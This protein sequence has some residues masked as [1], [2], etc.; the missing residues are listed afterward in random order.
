MLV[1]AT[2]T[3]VMKPDDWTAIALELMY[4][5]PQLGECVASLDDRALERRRSH[6]LADPLELV[7]K[8]VAHRPVVVLGW[9]GE[10]D[11]Q[12]TS[13]SGIL[14]FTGVRDGDVAEIAND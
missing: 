3:D 12:A 8:R 14:R 13:G 5:I 9:I 6:Y 1:D 2:V 11:E 7:A 4:T 10:H